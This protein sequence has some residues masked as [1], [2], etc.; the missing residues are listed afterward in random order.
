MYL[1]SMGICLVK[2]NENEN[3]CVCLDKALRTEAMECGNDADDDLA[4]IQRN[5]GIIWMRK[6]RFDKALTCFE[7]AVKIK[8]PHF[9]D[10]VKDH[11]HLVNC[12]DGALGAVSE[13]F[14][15]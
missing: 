2:R 8:I 14:G 15:T 1:Q 3:A 4:K 7:E 10:S 6:N 9:S 11:N 5:L 13:L 12:L